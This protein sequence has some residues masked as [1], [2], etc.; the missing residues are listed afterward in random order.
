VWAVELQVIRLK[1]CHPNFVN[2]VIEA[3]GEKA[4]VCYQCGTCTAGCP[5][6]YVMDYTPRQIMRMVNLG[7]KEEVLKSGT[8]WLCSSCYTC[9]SRCPRGVEITS[10]MGALKSLAIREGI[11][12]KNRM[13]PIFYNS[14]VDIAMA[15]GRLHEPMLMLKIAFKG[16]ESIKGALTRL[17][18]D[19]PLGLELV[20]K[21]KM[22]FLPHKIKESNQLK[23]IY[24]NVRRM[25]ERG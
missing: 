14:F 17:M 23:I 16:E 11:E 24:E 20:K 8:I 5:T 2:E 4:H 22:A 13:A 18:K 10:V 9:Q 19:A 12:A 25:E 1:D 7:M 6:V 15:Y 21:G 3:G